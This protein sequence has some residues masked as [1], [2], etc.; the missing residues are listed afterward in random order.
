[1]TPA[2]R[3]RLLMPARDFPAT[4]WE[5]GIRETEQTLIL[6]G[7]LTRVT[8]GRASY[9]LRADVDRLK[10]GRMATT[11]KRLLTLANR[12][13]TF[14]NMNVDDEVASL[15]VLR[16]D[17]ALLAFDSLCQAVADGDRYGKAY[18]LNLL[19]GGAR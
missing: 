13:L 5:H 17:D 1:M 8:V 15:S 9:Y 2:A 19:T 11:R 4:A 3:A 16:R 10:G 18:A 12:Q 14:P 7:R 6:T